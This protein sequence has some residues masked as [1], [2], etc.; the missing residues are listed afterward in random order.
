MAPIRTLAIAAA[1]LALTVSSTAFAHPN[2]GRDHN[3]YRIDQRD[4]VQ[5]V[6]R[7]FD[8]MDRNGD[9]VLTR[10]EIR[11]WN[12]RHHRRS[13]INNRNFHR[14]DRNDNGFIHRK[15]ARRTARRMFH[16]NDL[17]GNGYLG[18]REV[19]RAPW[20]VQ[21]TVHRAMRGNLRYANYRDRDHRRYRDGYRDRDHHRDGDRHRH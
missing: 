10:K 9:R 6:L 21:T 3:R 18:P 17:N 19:K 8:R 7:N 12:K 15:E 4:F 11:R 13:I 14:F 2:H 16:R 5:T 1:A 20:M